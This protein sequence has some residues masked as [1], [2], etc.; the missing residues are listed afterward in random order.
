MSEQQSDQDDAAT[1]VNDTPAEPVSE[2]AGEADNAPRKSRLGL[3]VT[4]V[5]LIAVVA[6]AIWLKQGGDTPA[7]TPT[8]ND[9]PA[10]RAETAAVETPAASS[11]APATGA[12]ATPASIIPAATQTDIDDLRDTLRRMQAELEASRSEV[13][14]LSEAVRNQERENAR[15]TA[16][17]DERVD[18]LDS[19]PGRVLNLE[20]GVETLQGISAG[21]RDA[22]LLAE[23]EYYMQIANAQVQL[24]NNPALAARALQL[25]DVRVRELANPSYTPVRRAIAEEVATLMATQD[26]DIEGITLSLGSLAA[27]VPTLPLINEIS[28]PEADGGGDV[29]IDT[30]SGWQRARAATSQAMSGM[31]RVRKS[32]ERVEA[33][34]SPEAEYFLRLNLQLQL[35]AARL[36]LLLG[37]A[38]G[39]RQSLEDAGSWLSEYFDT[40]NPSV[41]NALT[42]L[43]QTASSTVVTARPDV[44]GSL[45]LL[46]RQRT[47]ERAGE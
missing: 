41:A 27:M 32:D 8:A 10:Q 43:E 28:V 46:R 23:A 2:A 47:L 16:S 36:S 13:A 7:A 4:G 3:I 33:M 30:L 39:F 38:A 29:D 18:L 19:L 5:I 12:Q 37:D 25:A 24:A 22:W 35:Q 34:L 40:D 21:S 14:S 17:I 1:D 11:T 9:T 15:L 6:G 26:V 20:R 42:L 31:F 44:S 45:T